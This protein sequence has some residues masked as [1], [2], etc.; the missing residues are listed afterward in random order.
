MSSKVQ[1]EAEWSAQQLYGYHTISALSCT[2]RT[3]EQAASAADQESKSMRATLF[4]ALCSLL[5][6]VCRLHTFVLTTRL[7]FVATTQR[8]T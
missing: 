6:V 4:C 1:Y 7:A 3:D 2:E 8:R 5:I